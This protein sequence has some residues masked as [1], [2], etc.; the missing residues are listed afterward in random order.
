MVWG[1]NLWSRVAPGAIPVLLVEIARWNMDPIIMVLIMGVQVEVRKA[2][3]PSVS[4][5]FLAV[6]QGM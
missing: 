5:G 1:L 6:T 4:P 2:L 3:S